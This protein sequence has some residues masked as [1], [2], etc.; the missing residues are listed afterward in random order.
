[1]DGLKACNDKFGH[2]EGDHYIL[3]ISNCLK[4]LLPKHCQIFRVGGDEF[5]IISEQMRKADLEEALQNVRKNVY[6]EKTK[7]FY[8]RDF[9]F[10]C[11]EMD[12]RSGISLTKLMRCADR[13][14]YHAKMIHYLQR[15]QNGQTKLDLI[16]PV[17][18]LYN[19]YALLKQIR[20]IREQKKSARF[21]CVG[22]HQFT[23]VNTAWGY[24]F[25]NRILHTFAAKIEEACGEKAK[26]YRLDGVK[27]L[28]LFEE[29]RD[30]V[31][32]ECYKKLVKIG[33]EQVCVD[34]LRIPIQIAGAYLEFDQITVDENLILTELTHAIRQAKKDRTGKLITYGDAQNEKL[35]EEMRLLDCLQ[36]CILD[37]CR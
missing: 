33:R 18:N 9:S 25:G 1:M 19:V 20:K 29:P 2:T 22:I 34:G 5:L 32:S 30:G 13:E 26:L 15:K 36:T 21:L 3:F 6:R 11:A 24:D 16:D 8:L 27:F 10:G 7:H 23:E 31:R 35:R 28:L 17:T 4:E 14:M 37:G 12:P